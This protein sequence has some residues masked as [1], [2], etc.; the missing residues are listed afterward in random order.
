MKK[1]SSI[2]LLDLASTIEISMLL[3]MIVGLKSS[4][5]EP[6]PNLTRCR[7]IAA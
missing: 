2:L 4:L 1:Q 3:L 5:S 7:D 6:T